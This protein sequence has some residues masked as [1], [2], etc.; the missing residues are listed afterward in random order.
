MNNIVAGV[1]IGGSHITVALV[2]LDTLEIID[3]SLI[4]E[5]VDSAAVAEEIIIAWCSA[6]A[7]SFNTCPQSEKKLGIAMPGPFDYENG[8]SYIKDLHKYDSLYGLNVKELIAYHLDIPKENIRLNNDAACFLQGEIYKGSLEGCSVAVGLTLGTG[9][10]SAYMKSG[11]SFDANLWCTPYKGDII[12]ECISSRWFVRQF[13]QRAGKS[14]KDVKE[15]VEKYPDH[16]ITKEL[17]EEFSD[18]L[19]SFLAYFIQ[20]E[21]GE[22]VVLGGNISKAKD[23]FIDNIKQKLYESVGKVIPIYLSVLGERAALIGGAAQ[24]HTLKQL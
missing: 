3:K 9:L 22:V 14:V 18:N 15:I 17:F 7:K 2:N 5:R 12:E 24:F 13:Q 6:I 10:G 4:R 16:E 11:E 21:Q 23:F 1:D 20:K 8:I 19:A